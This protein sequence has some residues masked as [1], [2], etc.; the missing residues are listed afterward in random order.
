[1]R[2]TVNLYFAKQREAKAAEEEEEA[3]CQAPDA[4]RYYE[5]LQAAV[6]R[7]LFV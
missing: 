3:I 2:R 6:S 7:S 4:R 1:M 5:Q